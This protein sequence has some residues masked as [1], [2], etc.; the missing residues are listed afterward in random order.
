[1][2]R[3]RLSS[4][5]QVVIPAE[6]RASLG[7]KKGSILL[8]NLEGRRIVMEPAEELPPDFFIEAGEELMEKVLTEAKRS[9]DKAENLLRDLGVES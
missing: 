6:I 2:W 4:K 9:S 7:L 8:I 5:G 1:M 3:T